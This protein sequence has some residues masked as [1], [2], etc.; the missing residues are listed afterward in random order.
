MRRSGLGRYFVYMHSRVKSAQSSQLPLSAVLD[1]SEVSQ[2]HGPTMRGRP[3]SALRPKYSPAESG[4]GGETVTGEEADGVSASEAGAPAGRREVTA[5][6]LPYLT[7]AEIGYLSAVALTAVDLVLLAA[8]TSTDYL[9]SVPSTLAESLLGLMI[10]VAWFQLGRKNGNS[11]FVA[12][13]IFGGASAV[14]GL[15]ISSVPAVNLPEFFGVAE[16]ETFV[17]LV[18]F[19]LGVAAFFS[20]G[21]VFQVR[22]FRY[23]GYLLVVGFLVT[24][25]AGVVGTVMTATQPLCVPSSVGQ[26]CVAQ[27]GAFLATYGMGYL[28]S[29]ATTLVAG[30]GF[31]RVRATVGL[32]NPSREC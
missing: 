21:R 8:T 22:L 24:F 4:I 6:S 16:M 15:V 9:N 3:R 28:I 19:V 7:L 32:S 27:N 10:A 5:G 20:A 11:L 2:G 26:S 13:G 18:Y 30:I 23:A 12:A 1:F 14:L 25:A 29:A 17:S 31:R